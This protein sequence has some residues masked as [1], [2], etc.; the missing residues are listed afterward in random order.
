MYFKYE[1]EPLIMHKPE[2][3]LLQQDN[4]QMV[5]IKWKPMNN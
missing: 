3:S 5:Y 2:A 4:K 1:E